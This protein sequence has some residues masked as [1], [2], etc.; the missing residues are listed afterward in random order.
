MYVNRRGLYRNLN[1][2]TVGNVMWFGKQKHLIHTERMLLAFVTWDHEFSV[3][4]I[5]KTF[6]V[7]HGCHLTW[8][9]TP[10]V[11]GELPLPKKKPPVSPRW[12]LAAASVPHLRRKALRSHDLQW[13][14]WGMPLSSDNGSAEANRA[15]LFRKSECKL[16]SDSQKIQ[17]RVLGSQTFIMYNK[18]C[19]EVHNN[20]NNRP[21]VLYTFFDFE[22]VLIFY[23]KEEHTHL[24][25]LTNNVISLLIFVLGV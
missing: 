5:W 13:C 17:S 21:S 12:L 9:T 15:A 14:L 7:R 20:N 6:L 2:L 3:R 23:T 4:K 16:E 1:F 8:R 19:S 25:V 10:A 11:S 22:I 24:L 18:G